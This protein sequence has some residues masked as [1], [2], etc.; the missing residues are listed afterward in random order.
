MVKAALVSL[1]WWTTSQLGNES[2]MNVSGKT[3]LITGANRGMGQALVGEALRRGA[4]RIYA[5]TS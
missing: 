1:G 5:G 4:K 3:L 2:V